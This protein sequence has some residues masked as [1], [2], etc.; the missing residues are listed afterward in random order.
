MLSG[1]LPQEFAYLTHLEVLSIASN[2]LSGELPPD[3]CKGG[4]LQVFQVSVNMF[5]GPIPISL[6]TCTSLMDVFNYSNQITGDISN[7]GPS[8][9]LGEV[10]LSQ[11]KLCGHLSKSWASSINLTRL[12]V[13]ENMITGSLPPEFSNLANLEVLLLHTNNLQAKYQRNLVPIVGKYTA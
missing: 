4:N 6:K 3:V 1:P 2:S 5:T 8:P 12:S 11:N 10:D 13:A 9:H 7:F